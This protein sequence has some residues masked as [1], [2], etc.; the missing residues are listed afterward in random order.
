MRYFH[1]TGDDS[2]AGPSEEFHFILNPFLLVAADFLGLCIWRLAELSG[3]GDPFAA[4]KRLHTGN[5]P[6]TPWSAT[7]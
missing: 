2:I 3:V 7:S 5:T 1:G 4:A 6:Q